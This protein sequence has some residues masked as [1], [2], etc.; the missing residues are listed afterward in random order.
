MAKYKNLQDHKYGYDANVRNYEYTK[1]KKNTN[2]K[3]TLC[4]TIALC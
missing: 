2:N 4:Y 1:N 3:I